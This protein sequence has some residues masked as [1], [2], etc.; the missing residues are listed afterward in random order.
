MLQILRLAFQVFC[1]PYDLG[2]KGSCRKFLENLLPL[3]K[4]LAE[5]TTTDI[6]DRILRHLEYILKNDVLYDYFYEL[7]SGMMG[8]NEIILKN[9]LEEEVTAIVEDAAAHGEM[10]EAISPIV[11]ISLITQV[12]SLINMIKKI[13]IDA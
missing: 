1:R 10:P 2:D 3:M 7:I 5:K 4:T 6:D 12:I 11:I 13:K 9:G 8:T